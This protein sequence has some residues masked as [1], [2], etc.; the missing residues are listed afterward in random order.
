M[1][2]FFSRID[3]SNRNVAAEE[4]VETL[5]FDDLKDDFRVIDKDIES[6]NIILLQDKEAENLLLK[7]FSILKDN[8]LDSFERFENL[9]KIKRKLQKYSVAVYKRDF[10]EIKEYV[11]GE[12]MKYIPLDFVDT[13]YSKEEGLRIFDKSSHFI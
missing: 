1:Q 7:Y 3:G 13:I 10:D 5:K 8:K 2:D 6:E 4:D 11:K 9:K 12:N